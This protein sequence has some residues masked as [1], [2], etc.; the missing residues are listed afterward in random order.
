[1]GCTPS[2][3]NGNNNNGNGHQHDDDDD[4]LHMIRGQSGQAN[5]R[6]QSY[7]YHQTNLNCNLIKSNHVNKNSNKINSGDNNDVRGLDS[8]DRNITTNQIQHHH[9]ERNIIMVSSN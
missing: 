4:N 6:E 7:Y 9:E 2:S 3:Q 8:H 5:N 1:M